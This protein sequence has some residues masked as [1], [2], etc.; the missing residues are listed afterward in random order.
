MVHGATAPSVEGVDTGTV[1]S[2]SDANDESDFTSCYRHEHRRGAVKCQRCGRPI[3]TECMNQASVGFHCPECF[4]GGAQKIIRGPVAFDPMATKVLIGLSLVGM[5]VSIYMGGTLFRL[6]SDALRD[7]SLFAFKTDVQGGR[8]VGL[9][10]DQGEYYRLITSA[11]LHDGLMHIGFNMFALWI[12]GPQLERLLGRPRF[13][14]LYF[15]SLLGGSFG[16]LLVSPNSPT[17]GASGAVFGL[18]GAIM[19]VQ[20]KSGASIWQSGLG[21][22]L[23]INLAFTF[24]VPGVSIGGHLG[25]L[26]AGALVALLYISV[27]KARQ[28]EWMAYLG[29]L[30]LSA[31]L[32]AGSIWAAAQWANP[33]F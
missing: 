9:G 4:H 22:V 27:V 16:V 11:F 31:A 10:V 17:I 18:F 15:V 13:V 33:I 8:L 20:R 26:V 2:V 5:L 3:C 12:L 6:G 7:G 24:L 30:L 28:P 23:L 21:A 14:V 25:G 32:V 1:S 29:S 19:V